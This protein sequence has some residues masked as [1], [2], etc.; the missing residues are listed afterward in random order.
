MKLEG[1]ARRIFETAEASQVPHMAV[2]A[3]AA[4]TYGIP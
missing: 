4:G 3:I 1:I 2:G